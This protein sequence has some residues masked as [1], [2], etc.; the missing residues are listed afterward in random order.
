M[1]GDDTWSKFFNTYDPPK[2]EFVGE[3]SS[4]SEAFLEQFEGRMPSFLQFWETFWP[5]STMRDIANETN[6]YALE[7]DKRGYYRGGAVWYPINAMEL[8][9]FMVVLFYMGMKSQPNQKSY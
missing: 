5:F 3:E 7:V 1:Y 4:L 9:F 6:R 8:R 2:I